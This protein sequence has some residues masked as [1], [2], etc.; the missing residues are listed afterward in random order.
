MLTVQLDFQLTDALKRKWQC[1][2]IQVSRSSLL[3]LLANPARISPLYG[4]VLDILPGGISEF[5]SIMLLTCPL[6]I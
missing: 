2:T 5:A 1:G 4:S 3:L 6:A